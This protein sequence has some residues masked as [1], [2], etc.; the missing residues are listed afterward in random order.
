MT[1]EARKADD[2]EHRLFEF[3]KPCNEYLGYDTPVLNLNCAHVLPNGLIHGIL[4]DVEDNEETVVLKG[5]IV[6][7]FSRGSHT[8]QI[9]GNCLVERFSHCTYWTSL[10]CE[11]QIIIATCKVCQRRHWLKMEHRTRNFLAGSLR[12]AVVRYARE[13]KLK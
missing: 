1:N 13:I 4:F 5:H 2:L 7:G 6:T 9:V 11:A 8:L 12:C 10:L 3:S